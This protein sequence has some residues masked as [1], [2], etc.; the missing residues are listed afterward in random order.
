[1]VGED[2]LLLRIRLS[3]ES[4]EDGEAQP[5]STGRR[6]LDTGRRF[7]DAGEGFVG[8][9]QLNIHN[10]STAGED[11][12]QGEGVVQIKMSI[13]F[14]PGSSLVPAAFQPPPT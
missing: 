3:R 11:E 7:F 9:V 6:F 14:S 13:L 10:D 5:S 1:M 8:L 12:Q 2:G 4:F